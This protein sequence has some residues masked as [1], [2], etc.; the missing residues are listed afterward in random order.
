DPTKNYPDWKVVL[1]DT[2][3]A[4]LDTGYYYPRPD[5]KKEDVK[6]FVTKIK[7]LMRAVAGPDSKIQPT[8][9]LNNTIDAMMMVAKSAFAGKR[10]RVLCTYGTSQKPKEFIQLR[11]YPA[12]IEPMSVPKEKSRLKA[13]NID[14]M[15]R[16]GTAVAGSNGTPEAT[17]EQGY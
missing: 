14:V 8:T 7:H 13:G 1:K 12:F 4:L 11:S 6:K 5:D 9:G 10:F 2:T 15:I 16:P 17:A 3:G